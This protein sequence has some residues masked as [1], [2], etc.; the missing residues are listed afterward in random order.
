MA[1]RPQERFTLRGAETFTLRRAPTQ[2]IPPT[3]PYEL[4]FGPIGGAE[5]PLETPAPE[6]AFTLRGPEKFT[7]R[8]PSEALQELPGVPEEIVQPTAPITPEAPVGA[9][10]EALPI[11]MAR[12]AEAV[13]KGARPKFGEAP[14]A[15]RAEISPG[16]PAGDLLRSIPGGALEAIGGSLR[17]L[18]ELNEAL[19]T[20]TVE[21]L[22]RVLPESA[23]KV[24]TK[25]V[26]PWYLNPTDILKEPGI[27]I[28]DLAERVQVPEERQ[29]LATD[30]AEGVG[31][32]AGQLT[33]LLI[34]PAAGTVML[35]GLGADIQAQEAERAGATPGEKAAAVVTGAS[36]TALV[37][38]TGLDLLLNRVPPNIKNAA[39][40]Y[41]TD[42]SIGGGIEAVEEVVE[43]ILHNL[44]S[45]AIYDPDAKIFDGL[46][47]EAITAGG[48]GAIAR[49]LLTVLTGAKTRRPGVREEVAPSA[50]VPPAEPIKTPTSPEAIATELDIV[51]NGVQET[52]ATMPDLYLFT[53]K[54][55]GSTLAAKSLDEVESQLQKMRSAFQPTPAEARREAVEAELG[56][57][58]DISIGDV[59]PPVGM[60]IRETGQKAFD[61]Q[62][63][64]FEFEDA[65]TERA[66]KAAQGVRKEPLMDRVRS[67]LEKVSHAISRTHEHL[68]RTK[69][70]AK[71][72]FDLLKLQKQRGVAGDKTLRGLQGI[73]VNLGKNEYDL[74][75]RRVV[76]DDLVQSAA[77]NKE[78]P[79]GFTEESLIREKSRLD[80]KIAANPEIAA[81]IDK[82]TRLWDATRESYVES[83]QDI[84]FDVSERLKNKDYFRHQVLEYANAKS[85]YGTGKKLKTPT[86]RGFLRK[87]GGSALAINTDY[88]QAEYEVMAQMLYDIE[89]A[90]VISS[91]RSNYDISESVKL[92]AEKQGTADWRDEIPEGYTEWQPR[93]GNIFFLAD[94]IP[95]ELAE[96]MQTGALQSLNL[97]PED[98]K[99]FLAVGGKY[100]SFVVKDEVAA[101]L[102]NLSRASSSNMLANISK[103]ALTAWKVWTLISPRRFAKYN[104]RNVTGDADAAF[105][106]N[107]EG[108]KYLPRAVS[109]L[110]D[111]MIGDKAMT[112]DLKKWFEMGGIESTLTGQ[113]IG[114]LNRLKMFMRLH[115]RKGKP[116]EIPLRIWQRYWKTAR[117]TTDLR[118]ATLRYA[119]YL[120]YL[121]QM[122]AS[123]DNSPKNFGASIPDEIMGLT[124]IREKAFW[125]SNDLLG[126]YD[127]IGIVGHALREHLIPFWSWNE[128]NF[129]RNIQ[130]WKNAWND[131]NFTEIVGRR[132]LK[133]VA[134]SPLVAARV[135]KV[136]LKMTALWSILQ[137]WNN[138]KFPEEEKELPAEQRHRAHIIL[139]RD[140]DGKIINFT[141]LGAFSDFLEWFGLDA[142]PNHVDDWLSGKKTMKEIAIEMA[143]SPVNKI[144]QGLTP[145]I[146]VP[147]EL[148]TRRSLFPDIFKPGIVRDRGY[149]IA[150]NFGL[151]NEYRQVLGLPSRSY[152]ESLPLLFY[153][154]TDPLQAAY[155]DIRGERMKFLRRIGKGR[156][157]FMLSPRG[158]ALYN[159]KL[160]IRY[161]DKKAAE[162]YFLE[163]LTLGGTGQGLNR[164]IENMHPLSG[165]T[166]A[167]K[168]AF[169]ANLTSDDR[170][171]LVKANRFYEEV[172]KG[173]GPQPTQEE[174]R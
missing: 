15:E 16:V 96:K 82:R 40:R 31:Q 123:P 41:L 11:D 114:E 80:A 87:R 165:L 102:D 108:F 97:R 13:E 72:H 33:S 132:A 50:E 84:G 18:G 86:Q 141:R 160:A 161:Q 122:Q 149:H 117:I 162:K 92:E 113:E 116:G 120:S 104:I 101:T 52:P 36:V 24:L 119:N 58:V 47:R 51:Y 167:E 39:L 110:Y 140:K 68:P 81:A 136:M 75:T 65:E 12:Y 10:G 78:V 73:T 2:E 8:E 118:E 150:R 144:A 63:A 46:E 94:G 151:E 71:I 91:I 100:K 128:V 66:F 44:T 34:N 4:T 106:G 168:V 17:G 56:R 28:A 54:Q 61:E 143:Q 129:R 69:E 169:V 30:I 166:E 137:L 9:P 5:A 88:I 139:G 172:L 60:S 27:T 85:L 19:T 1:L 53:D 155:Y 14:A 125:L 76:L 170:E 158:D 90:K 103:K 146:K 124:D 145:F 156:E 64:E 83:M 29:N 130:F 23:M 153:Y 115:E 77:Q 147:A 111:T 57:E 171:R 7:L 22:R 126:A 45:F 21:G 42:I 163:Y 148:T 43:G 70:F 79:F 127:R 152:K 112:P 134:K 105:V 157:G 55:T 93:E 173:G 164:S 133:G 26:V 32:I 95:G 49:G 138:L 20:Y 135:G 62:A 121:E 89:V 59:K 98:I 67:T 131:P 109:E 174:G 99:R 74:F 37:E 3:D 48:A 159:F 154:K 25:P 142:A 35:S 38:K 6:E 107:P